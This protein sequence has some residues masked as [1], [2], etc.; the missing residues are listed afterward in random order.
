LTQPVPDRRLRMLEILEAAAQQYGKAEIRKVRF[1][2]PE[3]EARFRLLAL[4]AKL[5]FAGV[6]VADD[7]RLF[8]TKPPLPGFEQVAEAARRA[9]AVQHCYECHRE[10][11][12][13]RCE[14]GV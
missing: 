2:G 12:R 8:Q 7:G 14:N 11:S 6:F 1:S 9:G 13:C 10:Q 3:E 4:Q 5:I